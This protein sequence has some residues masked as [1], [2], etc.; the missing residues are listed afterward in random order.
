MR[1]ARYMFIS[2]ILLALLAGV[3]PI[4]FAQGQIAVERRVRLSR[5]KTRTIRGKADSSTSYVY[6]LRGE[7]DSRL[8]ARVSSEGGTA[9]FSIVP[10]GAQTL[11]N[12]AGVKE[13]T[14]AL[15]ETGE[16]SIVVAMSTSRDAEIPYTLEL[17]IR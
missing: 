6:K 10:P 5:G 7:K 9:T 1:A 3:L 8:E 12:A 16:Y 4:S 13:W 17:T 15:P 11:E 2:F 14:G